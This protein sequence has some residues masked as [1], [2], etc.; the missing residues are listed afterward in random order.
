MLSLNPEAAEVRV[1]ETP[2]DPVLLRALSITTTL[3]LATRALRG[4]E[5]CWTRI[6]SQ[7]P[8]ITG[9]PAGV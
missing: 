5:D 6:A 9:R 2:A 1:V 7:A 3:D 8:A 4:A